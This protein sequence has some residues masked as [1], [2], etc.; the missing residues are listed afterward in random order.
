MPTNPTKGKKMLAVE[1]P[2]QLVEEFRGYAGERGE[3]VNVAVERAL[4]REMAYPPPLPE[5]EPLPD[6]APP[7]KPKGRK[8]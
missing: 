8:R 3:R 6:A 1:L 7:A 4:R 2:E 5:L